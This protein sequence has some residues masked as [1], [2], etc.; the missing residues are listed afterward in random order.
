MVIFNSYVKLP[1]GKLPSIA[2]VKASRDPHGL[3]LHIFC[4][5]HPT[6]SI[7]TPGKV[8]TSE[9]QETRTEKWC[10]NVGPPSSKLV[11]KPH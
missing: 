3:S 2:R 5:G 4:L 10:Y 8:Q 1:E 9:R 11:Y 6:G 7:R